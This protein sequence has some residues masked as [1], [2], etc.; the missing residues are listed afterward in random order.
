MKVS[1]FCLFIRPCLVCLCTELRLFCSYRSTGQSLTV[2]VAFCQPSGFM[3]GSRWMRV[4]ESRFLMSWSP[5]RQPSHRWWAS[6]SSSSRPT[7]SLP[8]MLATYLNSGSTENPGLVNVWIMMISGQI[9]CIFSPPFLLYLFIFFTVFFFVILLAY[10][11]NPLTIVNN[12][13]QTGVI[14]NI[15]YTYSKDAIDSKMSA[16]CLKSLF[17]HNKI[18][19][20]D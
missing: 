14:S 8:C 6:L 11:I 7:T 19:Y 15:Q 13:S 1:L 5:E 17:L 4:V 3:E 18:V 9:S 20:L 12:S 16:E 10:S 2:S